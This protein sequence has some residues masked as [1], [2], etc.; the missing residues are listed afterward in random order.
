MKEIAVVILNWN[1]LELLKT[2]LPSVIEHS[3]LAQI[4]LADNGSTDTSVKWVKL[5]YPDVKIIEN[6]YNHGFAGGYNVALAN[7]EEPY[8][9]LI[10]SDIEVTENWL[11]PI[12]ETFKNN[13][14]IAVIQPKIKD[15]NNK[16]YFEYAGAAGGF[17]DQ[18]A[19][20]FCRG[21]IFDTVEEDKG[22]YDTETEIFWASGAC[23]F[24]KKEVYRELGG[25]DEDFFAHQEEIDLCWRIQN[26]GFK[27]QFCPSSTAYHLGGGTLST[28][29]TKK[30]FLN[31]RN[32][33]SMLLKNAPKKQLLKLIFIRLVLDGLAGIR[34]I[35]KGKPLHTI[36]I[37]KAHFAFY[38]LYSKMKS[39]RTGKEN[40][41]YFKINNLPYSY[42]IKKQ[43]KYS[44]LF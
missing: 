35:L 7:V 26:Q 23:F 30:T 21:R 18:L 32:S 36:A 43:T 1:G 13:E 15:Y 41:K 3:A 14:R 11:T 20:P 28:S 39:K 40:H 42:F 24:I 19:Y 6:Q 44:D 9:A 5:N 29:N 12:I 8:Y 4:Y 25:F 22:Q 16:D 2:F 34:F 17:I 37:I 31:F 33:L 38:A 27:I 10:N